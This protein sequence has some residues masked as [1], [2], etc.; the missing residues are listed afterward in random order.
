MRLVRQLARCRPFGLGGCLTFRAIA[1]AAPQTQNHGH[2]D[3]VK[4]ALHHTPEQ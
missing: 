1:G 3:T 4:H 2:T